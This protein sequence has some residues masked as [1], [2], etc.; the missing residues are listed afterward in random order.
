MRLRVK[1]PTATL[2]ALSAGIG[3][4]LGCTYFHVNTISS[5]VSRWT[6][7]YQQS[8]EQL[9]KDYLQR[10]NIKQLHAPNTFRD[11]KSILV[12]ENE[13]LLRKAKILCFVM[14]KREKKIISYPFTPTMTQSW[15]AIRNTWG[16]R[17]SRLLYFSNLDIDDPILEVFKVNVFDMTSWSATYE[18]IMKIASLKLMEEFEWFLKVEEDTFVIMENLAYFLSIYNSSDPHYFGHPYSWWGT[19]Y[20]AGGA[21]YV[22]SKAALR[23]VVKLLGSG[24]CES[25][26]TA[27]DMNLGRY[28]LFH[29]N[30][31]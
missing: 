20:N 27:E 11:H 22:L 30:S 5:T 4:L 28:Y 26:Y 31:I 3:F 13:Y 18:A 23:K 14:L 25:A 24:H 1:V 2:F 21:G 8:H 9:Y 7:R 12:S 6:K 16:N 15:E 10:G 29:S 19:S 17:C